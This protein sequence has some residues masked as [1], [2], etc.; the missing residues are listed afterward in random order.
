MMVQHVPMGKGKVFSISKSRVYLPNRSKV[1][2]VQGGGNLQALK[3]ALEKLKIQSK[4][5]VRF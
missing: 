1:A 3:N 4:K 5:Y 2:N